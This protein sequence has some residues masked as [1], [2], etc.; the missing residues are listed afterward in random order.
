MKYVGIILL[1]IMFGC[2]NEPIIYPDGGYAFINTDTIE[3][4]SFPYFPVRDSIT[5][6]DSINAI[7]YDKNVLKLFDESNISLKPIQKEIFRLSVMGM[8]ISCYYFTLTHGKLIT[9]KGLQ[10]GIFEGNN[11]ELSPLDSFQFQYMMFN[12]PKRKDEIRLLAKWKKHQDSLYKKYPEMNSAHHLIYLFEKAN[13]PLSNTFKYETR[14]ITLPTQIYR[15]LIEKINNS[16]YWKM[17]LILDCPNASTDGNSYI[18]EANNGKK[19]NYVR[20]GN[21]PDTSNKFTQTCQ[22]IINYAHYENE[23]KI[24]YSPR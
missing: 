2:N 3:D 13:F 10:M 1:L 21:C 19:Y 23:I 8:G 11:S 15:N 5:I 12:Y 18:L 17:S 16:N 14:I 22:E 7:F 4:K 20:F 24:D 9:K 6:R